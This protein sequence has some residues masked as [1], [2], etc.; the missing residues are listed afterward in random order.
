MTPT[1]SPTAGS[2]TNPATRPDLSTA[3]K[4]GIGVG[5]GVGTLAVLGALVF[6]RF[7][8]RRRKRTGSGNEGEGGG[9]AEEYK[10]PVEVAAVAELPSSPSPRTELPSH[11]ARKELPVSERPVEL[12]QDGAMPS[13][14]SA[15]GEIPRGR[16]TGTSR[17]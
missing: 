6:L 13:E 16:M 15:D 9:G 12:W 4:A 10:P 7:Y 5:V 14:L 17:S 3:A 8:L 1:V 11:D 2:D